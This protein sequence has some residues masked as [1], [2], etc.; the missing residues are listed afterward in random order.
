MLRSSP[1]QPNSTAQRGRSIIKGCEVKLGRFN[2]RNHL[3][4]AAATSSYSYNV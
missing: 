3:I 4:T 1:C 2:F